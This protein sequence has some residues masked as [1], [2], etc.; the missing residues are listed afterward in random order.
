[1]QNLIK[2]STKVE[3]NGLDHNIQYEISN[4]RN[5]G[6]DLC[7]SYKGESLKEHV[8]QFSI[9]PVEDVKVPHGELFLEKMFNCN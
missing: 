3:W 4:M 1:M 9:D 2:G 7:V 8:P 6:F 5:G